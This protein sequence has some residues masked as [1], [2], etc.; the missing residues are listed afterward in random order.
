MNLSFLKIKLESNHNSTGVIQNIRL[1]A[2]IH[3][4]SRPGRD[5][6]GILSFVGFISVYTFLDGSDST[7]VELIPVLCIRTRGR[8]VIQISMRTVLATRDKSTTVFCHSFISVYTFVDGSDL[9][10]VEH[11]PVLCVGIRCRP[12]I[13]TSI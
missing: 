2:R 13:E 9:T 6:H 8:P 11:I 4:T 3:D 5:H 1:R 10:R 7:R 12:V